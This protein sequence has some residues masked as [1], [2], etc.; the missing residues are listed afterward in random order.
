MYQNT[1][2][3]AKSTKTVFKARNWK[4][5]KALKRLDTAKKNFNKMDNPHDE[6]ND[7][8][9]LDTPHNQPHDEQNLDTKKAKEK[10]PD[11][12]KAK[13]DNDEKPH[14]HETQDEEDKCKKCI[15]RLNENLKDDYQR[16][17][18]A[19]ESGAT[20]KEI[21]KKENS[22][23]ELIIENE[24][25]FEEEKP[26]QKDPFKIPK[27]AKKKASKKEEVQYEERREKKKEKKKEKKERKK[28]KDIKIPCHKTWSFKTKPKQKCYKKDEETRYKQYAN[29][30][31]YYNEEDQGS[32]HYRYDKF[33]HERRYRNDEETQYYSYDPYSY[34]YGSYN[35]PR[36]FPANPYYDQNYS[37]HFE[38]HIMKEKEYTNPYYK[39]ATRIDVVQKYYEQEQR[40]NQDQRTEP[41]QRAEPEQRTVRILSTPPPPHAKVPEQENSQ[42]PKYHPAENDATPPPPEPG[43]KKREESVERILLGT[44]VPVIN[45]ETPKKPFQ[46]QTKQPPQ[47]KRIR[48]KAKNKPEVEVLE[49]PKDHPKALKQ[50]EF[51]ENTRRTNLEIM[52]QE[53]SEKDE[54]SST[55]KIFQDLKEKLALHLLIVPKQDPRWRTIYRVNAEKKIEVTDN[56]APPLPQDEIMTTSILK[57]RPN[58]C[59]K[60]KTKFYDHLEKYSRSTKNFLQNHPKLTEF[61]LTKSSFKEKYEELCLTLLTTLTYLHGLGKVDLKFSRKGRALINYHNPQEYL[62][63]CINDCIKGREELLSKESMIEWMRKKK[64]FKNKLSL[65]EDEKIQNQVKIETLIQENQKQKETIHNQ[66]KQIER[67]LL[68]INDMKLTKRAKK[69]MKG[70]V[71]LNVNH[72]RKGVSGTDESS[73][74]EDNQI[75]KKK[76][77]RPKPKQDDDLPPE[78]DDLP[79]EDDDLPPENDDLPHE[80]NSRD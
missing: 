6:H 13:E 1:D 48:N 42:S 39:P 59:Y 50:K 34:D 56:S 38:G 71:N 16:I 11:S 65:Q 75:P 3:L 14:Q 33:R 30:N 2:I 26:G 25:T 57:D 73:E 47:N 80:T 35:N 54:E 37:G 46:E 52:I 32:E 72:K 43:R 61:M 55:E 76:K 69:I 18:S 4:F 66:E 44:T 29:Y 7:E 67:L 20:C 68:E 8:Q 28:M 53:S 78:D 77:T 79:P 64:F 15:E 27:K 70:L 74:E 9:N 36:H 21:E 41:E 63:D 60:I 17:L 5:D 22:P 51:Q 10:P 24:I 12:V 49:N 23:E 31:D 40:T 45:I 19:F 58:S 62:Q